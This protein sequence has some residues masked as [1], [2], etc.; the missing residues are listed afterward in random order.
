M[1][2]AH[3]EL[4]HEIRALARR[5]GLE[6]EVGPFSRGASFSVTPLPVAHTS[7]P[8][9]GYRLDIEGK[10]VAWAPEFFEFPAWIDDFDLVFAEAAGFEHPIRFAGGVGG[11]ASA[12]SVADEARRRGV[13][14]L[15]FAHVGR[16]TIRAIDSGKRPSFGEL[17]HDGQAFILRR[18]HSQPSARAHVR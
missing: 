8:T 11:H 7:H 9:F 2:D 4:M 10:R 18:A 14:Q 16:P 1:T 6:P 15:V 5:H 12:M 17:G 13:K 3:S